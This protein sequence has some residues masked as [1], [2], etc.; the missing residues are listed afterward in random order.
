[1][2]IF[3]GLI[4]HKNSSYRQQ[5]SFHNLERTL[6]GLD[7]SG[8]VTV[9]DDDTFS[10]AD[11]P[12]WLVLARIFLVP[13][14]DY[15]VKR[16]RR[17]SIKRSV[18]SSLKEIR[19]ELRRRTGD[20]AVKWLVR[21]RNI[22]AAHISLWQKALESGVDWVMV[23]EDDVIIADT[24]F[25]AKI[26]SVLKYASGHGIQSA[27]IF[28]S[29]SFT[30]KQHMVTNLASQLEHADGVSFRISA[31][32]GWSDTVAATIYS[33]PL[34]EDFLR[35]LT[36]APKMMLATLPIDQVLDLFLIVI[37]RHATSLRTI[38]LE[39]AICQ[40]QSLA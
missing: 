8:K 3:T 33:R 38:H 23:I 4:T 39:P 19:K 40:Q 14:M 2:E 6:S 1:M 29:G 9:I 16:F 27:A 34:L 26:E 31:E 24:D 7:R 15:R 20:K 36:K 13:V 12:R 35:F 32:R 28:L 18:R 37:S 30:P 10:V 5:I 21:N 25:S 17:N 11:V 22:T